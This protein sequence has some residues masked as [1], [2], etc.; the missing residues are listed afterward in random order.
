MRRRPGPVLVPGL[1]GLVRHHEHRQ[2][3]LAHDLV[4]HA[5][6]HRL[7][8]RAPPGAQHDQPGLVAPGHVQQRAAD[9]LPQVPLDLAGGET[10]AA[11]SCAT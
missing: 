7:H 1:G 2:R 3:G 6:Q 10:P 5:A 11:A 8:G 4:R 9:P